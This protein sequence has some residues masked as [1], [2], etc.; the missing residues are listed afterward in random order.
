MVAVASATGAIAPIPGVSMAI[1]IAMIINKISFYKSQ[2]GLPDENS[3]EF[4]R[5]IPENQQKVLKYCSSNMV[6]MATF[7]AGYSTKAIVEELVRLIPFV[8]PGIAAGI[9]F[10]STYAFLHDCLDE[11]EETAEDLLKEMAARA[12]EGV[13]L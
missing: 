11:L 3:D 8:G 9:S 4:R 7:I 13:R 2:L 5:L 6:Q 10:S 1:D 12:V